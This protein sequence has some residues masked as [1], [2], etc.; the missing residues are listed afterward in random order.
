MA[1]GVVDVLGRLPD[2]ALGVRPAHVVVEAGAVQVADAGEVAS[3]ERFYCRGRPGPG[4]QPLG[5]HRCGGRRLPGPSSPRSGHP[6]P[7]WWRPTPSR[8]RPGYPPGPAAQRPTPAT[9]GRP[10]GSAR[11]GQFWS[12]SGVLSDQNRFGSSKRRCVDLVILRC[13]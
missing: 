3:D 9:R 6:S 7:A 2:R 13:M 4:Q 5:G 8:M 1:L 11:C 10:G 12:P